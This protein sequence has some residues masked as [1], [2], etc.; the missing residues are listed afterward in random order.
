MKEQFHKFK[1]YGLLISAILLSILL[2]ACSKKSQYPTHKFI[3]SIKPD[4]LM[5]SLLT[6]D[7]DNDGID[8]Y[9]LLTR[10]KTFDSTLNFF[11]FDMVEFFSWNP[12]ENDYS[13]IYKDTV[14]YGTEI[15]FLNNIKDY[16]RVIQIKTNSGGED[17]NL[18][19]G[20]RLY[21]Y[22]SHTVNPIF[23]SDAGNPAFIDLDRDS[24]PEIILNGV[25][26][27]KFAKSDPLTFT[28]NIYKYTNNRYLD[29]TPNYKNVFE[30]EIYALR[31]EY[32]KSMN[33]KK[34][35][36]PNNIPATFLK[37]C[38]N[39]LMIDNYEQCE[40]F[41]SDE[42]THIS[43]LNDKVYY[44]VLRILTENGMNY[45]S[46]IDSICSKLYLEAKRNIEQK[47]YAISE[48]VLQEI[49][50][51][52]PE[53]VDAYL[54][55]GNLFNEKRNYDE[56]ISYFQQGAIFTTDD[57]RLYSGLGK[58]YMG[59]G[60]FIKSKEYFNKYLEMDSLSQEAKAIKNMISKK[61]FN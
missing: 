39:Y 37:I 13:S 10:E 2:L 48:N 14:Y 58:S 32:F 33:S 41:V 28:K 4:R 6:T 47:K 9:I 52:D 1:Y 24:I 38:L 7:L 5:D 34:I 61:E 27:F 8:E 57:K 3:P 21:G 50:N 45:K 49:L 35:S 40:K 44:D 31:S 53:F 26:F 17:L 56:A 25:V 15:N 55:L 36:F 42:K 11:K 16:Q 51:L 20:M 23:S 19:M 54:L 30:N 59:K 12:K 46:E 18:S 29:Q 60:E 22:K 43:G